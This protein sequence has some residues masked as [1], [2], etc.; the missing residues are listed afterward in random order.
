M[1]CIALLMGA[2]PSVRAYADDDVTPAV[3]NISSGDDFDVVEEESVYTVKEEEVEEFIPSDVPSEEI[4]INEITEIENNYEEVI[5]EDATFALMRPEVLALS[6]RVTQIGGLEAF[7]GTMPLANIFI[8]EDILNMELYKSASMNQYVDATLLASDGNFVLDTTP[9]GE[10]YGRL[11]YV[12][13]LESDQDNFFEGPIAEYVVKGA[14]EY[15]DDN[16]LTHRADVII[17]YSNLHLVIENGIGTYTPKAGTEIQ[18]IDTNH[19]Y[20]AMPDDT[21]RLGMKVDANIKVVDKN[22]YIVPGYFICPQVDLDVKRTGNS[23]FA[24]LFGAEVNSN[25]DEA[26]ELVSNYG[27]P[28]GEMIWIP[29]A[30]TTTN[31]P[32]K[33][34]VSILTTSDGT[35]EGNLVVRAN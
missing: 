11:N 30:G 4:Y 20:P 18:I 34:F 31:I 12:G 5:E 9:G 13:S 7:T 19:I 33:G 10:A 14:A 2:F 24:R 16:G 29:E 8:D 3:E 28:N 26:L 22:G 32:H 35:N 27:G 23:G 21:S 6:N 17:T 25:Y 1:L 15:T